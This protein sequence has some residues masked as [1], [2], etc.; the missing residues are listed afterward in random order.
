MPPQLPCS[1]CSLP[2]TLAPSPWT[3]S[4]QACAERAACS[5]RCIRSN[6]HC[7]DRKKGAC[8]WIAPSNTSRVRAWIWSGAGNSHPGWK[9]SSKTLC[10]KL[11]TTRLSPDS[12]SHCSGTAWSLLISHPSDETR[13]I[14]N[15][16]G[17][18]GF[19]L[20]SSSV[21]RA[22]RLRLKRNGS[23][24]NSRGGSESSGSARARCRIRSMSSPESNSAIK[25]RP[26]AGAATRRLMNT[27]L[28]EGN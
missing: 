9:S 14:S 20:P 11:P 27:R 25:S 13:G 4:R 17:D 3:I 12:G 23:F 19:G 18:S 2:S 6:C 24:R 10:A 21:R 16:L 1:H 15:P 5:A 7:A 28:S 8:C 26:D 22:S